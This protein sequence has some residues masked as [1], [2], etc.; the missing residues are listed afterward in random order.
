MPDTNLPFA[1]VL[2]EELAFIK[3]R[4]EKI[5]KSAQSASE[6]RGGTLAIEDPEDVKLAIEHPRDFVNGKYEEFRAKWKLDHSPKEK[7]DHSPKDG[8]QD[9]LLAAAR[10]KALSENLAGLAFSGGGIRS[11]T[12][13]IGVLQGLASLKLLRFFDV[14]STVS[15]GGYAGGWLATWIR[16]EGDPLNVERQLDF[17]R[18]RQGKAVRFSGYRRIGIQVAGIVDEE[19]RGCFDQLLVAPADGSVRKS[20]QAIREEIGSDVCKG[21][22]ELKKQSRKQIIDSV[23]KL[24]RA[25]IDPSTAA[26]YGAKQQEICDRVKD[27]LAQSL[28][29][30]E[31]WDADPGRVVDEELRGC[32]DQLLVAPAD[33]SVR[34]SLQAIR[35]EIGL[36]V[37]KGMKELKEESCNQIIN[38]VHKKIDSAQELICAR[39][40]TSTAAAYGAKQQE[41]LDRV[42]DLLARP[43]PLPEEGD[44]D[45]DQVD[46]VVDEEPG[47]IRH[48]RR[49]SSYLN[50]R[51]GIFSADSWT[52]GAIY[53]RNVLINLLLLP[54]AMTVVLFGR[55]VIRLYDEFARA[56][57]A[58]SLTWTNLEWLALPLF[59]VGAAFVILAVFLNACVLW[60]IRFPKRKWHM[61]G[62]RWARLLMISMFAGSVLVMMSYQPF[63]EWMRERLISPSVDAPPPDLG[64]LGWINIWYHMKYIGLT[65][66]A[67]SIATSWLPF[68]LKRCW[69]DLL[70]A[71]ELGWLNTGFRSRRWGVG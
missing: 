1:R 69:K 2:I 61:T 34:K 54:L 26:A 6:E 30:P 46:D 23:P 55:G 57:D 15:G 67:I 52:L 19:L 56:T 43:L 68:V 13:A 60:R 28:P 29:L 58:K 27:L 3:V 10:V 24:I 41:I 37:C 65:V 9:E 44:V 14:L 5:F 38:L 36:A 18:I 35:E 42:K 50:P 59:V 16:R 70:V 62:Y 53:T 4:R 33:G 22:K 63:L 7:L 45:P 66:L 51:A 71:V 8:N 12:F 31:E 20:L 21:M 17:S 49:Y 48:L 47:P 11:A 40:D 25:R 39:I 32:F 64:Y